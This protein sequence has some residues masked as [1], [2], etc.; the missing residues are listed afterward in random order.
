MGV[1]TCRDHSTPW[2]EGRLPVPPTTSSTTRGSRSGP[3]GSSQ[4][5]VRIKTNY[6]TTTRVYFETEQVSEGPLPQRTEEAMRDG[7]VWLYRPWRRASSWKKRSYRKM[8]PCRKRISSRPRELPRYK[9]ERRITSSSCPPDLLFGL[10]AMIR[11]LSQRSIQ[12]LSRGF[13]SPT[14]TRGSRDRLTD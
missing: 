11:A 13:R 5:Q 14:I 2:S 8:D 3:V 1:H 7:I 6:T 10:V 4:H 9:I 12:I